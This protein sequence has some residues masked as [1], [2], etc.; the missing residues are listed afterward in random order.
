MLKAFTLL[1]AVTIIASGHAPAAAGELDVN[2]EANYEMSQWGIA[3]TRAEQAHP[4]TDGAGVIVAVIDTGVD[5]TH[6]DLTG[7]VLAG[8][9]SVKK[10]P[11]PEG[12]AHDVGG[13]G[14]HVAGIIAGSVNNTGI[15]GVAPGVR[16]L[17]VQVLGDGGN[18]SDRTVADGIDWAVAQGAQVI[19]LSL[20]GS[21]NPFSDGGS[22]SCAS[23]GAAYDADVVVVVAAGNAGAA[24][25][26]RNEPASCRGAISVAAVDEL[27]NRT[28]FSSYDSTVSIAAPGAAIVSSLPMAKGFPYAQWNGTSMAAPHVAGAAALV[29][30]AHPAW[31]ARQVID[32]LLTTAVDLGPAGFDPEY[33]HGLV[34]AAAAVGAERV[35]RDVISKLIAA[36][37]IPTIVAVDADSRAVNVSWFAPKLVSVDRYELIVTDAGTVT[38]YPVAAGNTRHSFAH[39]LVPRRVELVAYVN[40]G[41]RTSVAFTDGIVNNTVYASSSTTTITG[42]KAR[43]TSNGIQLTYTSKGS[44]GSASVTMKAVDGSFFVYETI[45]SSLNS[46]FY[47]VDPAAPT[48]AKSVAISVS[49]E[50]SSRRVVLAPQYLIAATALTAGPDW[51]AVTGSTREACNGP[52]KRGCSGS[53]VELRDAK[54][55]KVVANVRVLANLRFGFDLPVRLT[56]SSVYVAIGADRSPTLTWQ[57]RP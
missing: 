25:N 34:D 11:L 14:T 47:P 1:C 15:A 35:G 9:S 28:S 42:L 53:F 36:R 49:T 21:V 23:V 24:G 17:P 40:D 5:A 26:P 56:P 29:R 57:V 41:A 16:I 20:G 54:S 46:R 18:G 31:T 8:W 52:N 27:L 48:R 50:I 4:V 19:N 33:G 38:R 3:A 32:R 13:H 37:T 51:R 6:P 45:S 55:N 7:K 39:P 10:S 44:L 22:R 43:W 12:G 30:A 2:R